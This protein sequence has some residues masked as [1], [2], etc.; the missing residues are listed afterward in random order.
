M[1]FDLGLWSFGTQRSLREPTS[2]K[3]IQIFLCYFAQNQTDK[4]THITSLM[5][6]ITTSHVVMNT[7]YEL[8]GQVAAVFICFN[9]F[10]H[11]MWAI[12]RFSLCVCVC[13]DMWDINNIRSNLTQMSSP[14][15][16]SDRVVLLPLLWVQSLEVIWLSQKTVEINPSSHMTFSTRGWKP[17][18]DSE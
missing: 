14:Q 11:F 4:L 2:L 10:W 15:W 1:A 13:V 12:Y 5:E 9:Y 3:S 18:E 7:C 17:G 6:V 8:W 16:G